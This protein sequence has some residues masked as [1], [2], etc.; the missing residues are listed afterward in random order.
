MMNGQ[1][2]NEQRRPD[3]IKESSSVEMQLRIAAMLGAARGLT[4]ISDGM[5]L[6]DRTEWDVLDDSGFVPIAAYL[7]QLQQQQQGG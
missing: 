1:F 6:Q 7:E 4:S 2:D 5:T 3:V